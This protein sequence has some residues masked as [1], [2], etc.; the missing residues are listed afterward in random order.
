VGAA[1]T[2]TG[3]LDGE[4]VVGVSAAPAPG[5]GVIGGDRRTGEGSPTSV[6]G[7]FTGAGQPAKQEDAGF[8]SITVS[9]GYQRQPTVFASGTLV[10]GC[11]AGCPTIFTSD[12]GGGTWRRL[13]A[14]GFDG[15][16]ILLPP[17]YPDDRTIF[18][19]GGKGLQRS[20]DGGASF[21]TVVPGTASAAIAP[22]SKPGAASILIGGQ[23]L[24]VY[25]ADSGGLTAGPVLPATVSSVNGVAFGID[26][27]TIIVT[28]TEVASA[29]SPGVAASIVNCHTHGDCAT[30][31]TYP[32]ERQL[33]VV[34]ARGAT[35]AGTI[36]AYSDFGIHRSTDDGLHFTTYGG[37]D[38]GHLVDLAPVANSAPAQELYGAWLDLTDSGQPV[39]IE[40]S[41]NGGRTFDPVPATGLDQTLQIV[42]LAVLPDGKLLAAFA[43]ADRHGD[44][45]LRCSRDGGSTWTRAC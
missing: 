28:G 10:Y 6:V 15:G 27:G 13:A 14:S 35:G 22:D 29:G 26:R 4:G 36:L 33:E 8:S 5:G 45:G 9:P 3:V 38:Q 16:R 39:A 30:V 41:R 23:P 20:D 18:A 42:D 37:L 25:H 40:H 32:A 19:I 12:D 43:L 7:D 24:L 44:F 34:V 2:M 1:E 21:R 31:A 11:A 17:S